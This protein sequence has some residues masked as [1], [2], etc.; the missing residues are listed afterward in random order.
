MLWL[1]LLLLLKVRLNCS[2]IQIGY[3]Q[4]VLYTAIN[5]KLSASELQPRNQGKGAGRGPLAQVALQ[6]LW[7]GVNGIQF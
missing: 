3:E 4:G 7:P 1:L 2:G 5:R 6:R